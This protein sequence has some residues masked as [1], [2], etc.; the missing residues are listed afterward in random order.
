[1]LFLRGASCYESMNECT[2]HKNLVWILVFMINRSVLALSQ[3]IPPACILLLRACKI[4]SV[5]LDR[6]LFTE[7]V[8]L[9][10]GHD[11]DVIDDNSW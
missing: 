7:S 5:K 3:D 9:H 11:E 4:S 6:A 10:R 8:P 2:G 1:M